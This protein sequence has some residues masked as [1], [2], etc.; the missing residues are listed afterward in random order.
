MMPE[1]SKESASHAQIDLADRYSRQALFLPIGLQGQARLARSRVTVLGCGGLGTNLANMIARAG[2]GHLSIVDRDRVELSNLQRQVLFDEKDARE[3]VFKAEAAARHL[4]EIN[5]EIEIETHIADVTA[6][7]IE[8]IVRGSDL[9]L[10]G[11]DNLEGRFL[12]NDACV[13]LAIPWIYGACVAA[14]GTV[15]TVWP[16]RTPCLRCVFESQPPPGSSDSCN[17]VGVLAPIVSVIA[18]LEVGEAIK[19]LSGNIDAICTDLRM[20]DVWGATQRRVP[21][22][23]FDTSGQCPACGL[24]RF[25]YLESNSVNRP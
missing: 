15:M 4:R 10:D 24:R 18:A 17:T 21:L 13:K 23:V 19:I 25:D 1:P 12:I 22:S 3:R 7:N 14:I 9:V 6:H 11:F 20:V 2:V 8:E 5:S 16:P